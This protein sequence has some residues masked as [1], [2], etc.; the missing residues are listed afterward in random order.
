MV[1]KSIT[2]RDTEI[3]ELKYLVEEIGDDKVTYDKKPG[4]IS[5]N[6]VSKREYVFDP[7][8]AGVYQINLD[9]QT[10]EIE[11]T[12]VPDTVETFEWGGSISD[13]YTS[14]SGS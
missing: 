4:E 5:D 9:G 7:K 11:V 1:D 8:D 12:S 3:L 13:R 2:I 10:I 6:Y 14:V